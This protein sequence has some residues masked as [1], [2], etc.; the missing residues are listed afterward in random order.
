MNI[1]T[2]DTPKDFYT[3]GDLAEKFSLSLDGVRKYI[4]A[5]EGRG[6]ITIREIGTLKVVTHEDYLKLAAEREAGQAIPVAGARGWPAGKPRKA[7]K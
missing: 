7:R 3:T 6:L 2:L 5:A 4:K 1:P